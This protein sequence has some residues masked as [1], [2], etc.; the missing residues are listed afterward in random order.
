MAEA[1]AR[2]ELARL[3]PHQEWAVGSAGVWAEPGYPA[4][5]TAQEAAAEHGLD[6]SRHS[7][8]PLSEEELAQTDLVLV[9]EARHKEALQRLYPEFAGRVYM[10]SELVGQTADI[11]DPVGLPLADYR[12]TFEL[13]ATLIRQGAP[14]LVELAEEL[15]G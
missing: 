11:A 13:L 14:R 1:I 4:T 6:L 12:A 5:I 7:S 3:Y 8:R 10:L 2:R 15:E 9:M